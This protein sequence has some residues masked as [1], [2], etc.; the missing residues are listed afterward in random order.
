LQLNKRLKQMFKVDNNIEVK[1]RIM[2]VASEMFIRN[3]YDGTSVRDI[4][5]AADT[6]V[7]MV[8]YYYGSKYNLFEIIFEKALSV[9]M[10]RVADVLNS[11]KPFFEVVAMWIGSYYETLLEYPQIPVFILNEIN[12]NPERLTERVRKYQPYDIFLKISSRI[13]E[14]VQ[15]GTIR[16]TSTIDFMLNVLS[17]CIFPF[18]F[19]T[20]ATRVAGRTS[21]EY[22]EVLE[23]HKAHVIDFVINAIKP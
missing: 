2:Q 6:N 19:G 14:E 15:K 12:Q 17:M 5:T 10:R 20:M 23:N 9:L 4:A 18:M 21:E 11:D 3:G 22:Q 7:A 8:N 16:E 13:D 1:D